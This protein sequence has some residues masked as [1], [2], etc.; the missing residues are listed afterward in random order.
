MSLIWTTPADHA[1]TRA[2]PATFRG[3]TWG[4]PLSHLMETVLNNVFT[5]EIQTQPLWFGW[6]KQRVLVCLKTHTRIIWNI[7]T[8]SQAGPRRSSF[9]LQPESPGWQRNASLL[10]CRDVIFFPPSNRHGGIWNHTVTLTGAPNAFQGQRKEKRER[11]WK[12]DRR[13]MRGWGN[14]TELELIKPKLWQCLNNR[15][16]HLA[17][18]RLHELSFNLKEH[19]S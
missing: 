6:E 17:L 15:I 1:G 10:L 13:N 2:L 19:N 16:L 12:K 14:Y 11:E 8:R 18:E 4:L 3:H 9:T 5:L 7:K